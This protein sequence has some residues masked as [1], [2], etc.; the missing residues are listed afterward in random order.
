MNEQ[1]PLKELLSDADL[2]ALAPRL[3]EGILAAEGLV[4]D[5]EAAKA[6]G[7]FKDAARRVYDAADAIRA[8][9]REAARRAQVPQDQPS[10][11]DP[12]PS[13]AYDWLDESDWGFV[14]QYPGV[15]SKYAHGPAGDAAAVIRREGCKR[16]H[17]LIFKDGKEVYNHLSSSAIAAKRRATDK[18]WRI[19]NPDSRLRRKGDAR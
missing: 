17:C 14:P 12:P 11:K 19:L 5:P 10:P 18:L 16:F 3:I 1:F 7:Y 13:K 6:K 9:T 15:E 2:I 4:A 8:A